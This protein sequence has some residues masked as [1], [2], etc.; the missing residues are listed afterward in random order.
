M[1]IYKKKLIKLYKHFS[2]YA[3]SNNLEAMPPTPALTKWE[4]GKK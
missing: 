2:F 3:Y 1:P 4:G